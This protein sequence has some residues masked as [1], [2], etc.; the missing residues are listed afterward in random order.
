MNELRITAKELCYTAALLGYDRLVGVAYEYPLDEFACMKELNEVKRAL[1]KRRLLRE[2]AGG[3][4]TLAE[5]LAA[6][7][8]FCAR[9][10][11]CEILDENTTLYHARGGTMRLA[12][13]EDGYKASY[14]EQ[15]AD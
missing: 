3:E 4:I 14:S 15:E 9:P 13:G 7:A 6:C 1:H 11:R 12:R 10:E 2:S 5:E 8:A